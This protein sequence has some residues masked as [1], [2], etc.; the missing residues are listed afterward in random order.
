M[1]THFLHADAKHQRLTQRGIAN[2]LH[3]I[4]QNF[5]VQAQA[6]GCRTMS[7]SVSPPVIT[8]IFCCRPYFQ[9]SVCLRPLSEAPPLRS[10]SWPCGCRLLHSLHLTI[11]LLNLPLFGEKTRSTDGRRIDNP[12]IPAILRSALF[13]VATFGHN[14]QREGRCTQSQIC[15]RRV[16]TRAAHTGA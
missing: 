1:E 2:I 14:D 15:C 12:R 6:A 10:T 8:G 9:P 3:M 7:E 16:P 4:V 13:P 11:Y 5:R